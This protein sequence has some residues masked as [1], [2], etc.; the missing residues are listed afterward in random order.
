MPRPIGS[1][2]ALIIGI[3]VNDGR[4]PVR[5]AHESSSLIKGK[6]RSYFT[7]LYNSIVLIIV[8]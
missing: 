8:I 7:C 1:T 6:M 4:W 5:H 3:A 2:K